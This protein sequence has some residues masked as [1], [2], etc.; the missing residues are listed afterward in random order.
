VGQ[1]RLVEIQGRTVRVTDFSDHD[2]TG[3][4]PTETSA[5]LG[6]TGTKLFKFIESGVRRIQTELHIPY[7][8]V[9]DSL[10]LSEGCCRALAGYDILHAH[11]DLVPLGVTLASRKL[12]IPL[13]LDCE[14]DWFDEYRQ[15]NRRLNPILEYWARLCQRFC[16]DTAQAIIC[17]S[18]ELRRHLIEHWQLPPGKLHVLANGVD[19]KAFASSDNVQVWRQKLGINGE[20]AVMFVG[21]F[22]ERH[23]LDELVESF[24]QVLKVIPSCRLILVGDGPTRG[25][26]QM[27]VAELDLEE[28]VIWAG[29]VE[30]QTIP[31]L[32][33]LADVV[34]CPSLETTAGCKTV[35][36]KTSPLKL[37]EYMAAG[38]A[39]VAT[40]TGQVEEIITHEENG[41]LVKPGDTNGFAVA[42]VRLLSA[43]A[44]RSRIG[45]N[46]QQKV[47]AHHSWRQYGKQ[48]ETAYN[49]EGVD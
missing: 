43:P 46:A 31:N 2:D 20:P 12:N 23:A 9:W 15:Q 22:Y 41:L 40:A 27:R 39:C 30:H 24:A 47:L 45:K 25:N 49:L 35:P 38:K 18:N 1:V 3:S 4:T 13:I 26:I 37:F 10:R 44:E 14:G 33:G 48:L 29:R 19:T 8:S 32:L 5:D 17:V 11:F 28:S 21:G 6:I 34:V 16:F 7:F 42:I 36:L